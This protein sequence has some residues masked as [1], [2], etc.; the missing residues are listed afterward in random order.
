MRKK[1]IY[2]SLLRG[3]AV[4]AVLAS[5]FYSPAVAQNF[6]NRSVKIVV[7]FPPGGGIDTLARP[8]AEGL[9]LAWGQPVIVEN[10]PGGSTAVGAMAV[11]QAPADGYT[12]FFT[13]GNAI[14]LNPFILKKMP[15]D[16]LTELV[17]LTEVAKLH[18]VVLMNP[19][20][21]ATTLAEL[22]QLAKNSPDKFN[23]SSW[24]V[25]SEPQLVFEKLRKQAG[26]NIKHIPYRGSSAATTAVLA[27]ETQ[28]TFVSLTSRPFI[29]AGKVKALAVNAEKRLPSLPDVPTLKEAGY[30]YLAP[31]S[32]IG[33][34]APKSTPPDVLDK[35]A[36]DVAK[37]I[38]NPEF[39]E[40]YFTPIGFSA[41]GS[42]PKEFG[43]FV[44]EDAAYNKALVSELGIEP[45]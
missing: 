45:E 44:K 19:E 17:P 30:G 21:K 15:F 31:K 34:L 20:V 39:Q 26:V 8:I 3:L 13:S 22:F 40:K 24:G 2:A 35:I 42:S 1:T 36:K 37:I 29:E 10:K 32:W 7:P 14:S 9:R 38:M 5:C 11:A 27:G 4:S 43:A 16:P 28:M 41:V 23:Y 6:P 18:Q 12:L 33:M 25:G